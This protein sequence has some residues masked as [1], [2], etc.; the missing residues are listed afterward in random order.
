MVRKLICVLIFISLLALP[1]SSYAIPFDAEALYSAVFVIYRGDSEGSGFAIGRD[2]IVTNAHVV[3][4]H[5]NIIVSSYSGKRYAASVAVIDIDFDIALL[6][7]EDA[8]F[9]YLGFA[10]SD[11]LTIGEDV[12]AIGAPESMAYT[13]T[14]GVL[15]AKGRIIGGYEYL[16][17]DTALNP[18]N[19]GGPLLSAEGN[20][21][22]VNTMKLAGSEGI[23]LAIPS[24]VVR[25]FLESN[26]VEVSEP[27]NGA[28]ATPAAETT[29]AAKIPGSSGGYEK[30]ETANLPPVFVLLLVFS[31]AANAVLAALLILKRRKTLAARKERTDFDIDILE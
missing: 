1:V 7:V 8:D 11:S 23:G 22:G 9:P 6:K 4:G 13:L 19:S 17:V 2:L 28:S 20:V 25:G 30:T 27:G 24:N 29:A 5:G 10:D 18:G 31:L 21:I 15:S 16:Q 14:K 12:Y 26:G 3:E